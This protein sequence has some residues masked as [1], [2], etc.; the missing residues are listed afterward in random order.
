MAKIVIQ[1]LIYKFG[2]GENN[3]SE[4]AAL[5]LVAE[6]G[7]QVFRCVHYLFIWSLS[8]PAPCLTGGAKKKGKRKRT[9]KASEVT[10]TLM[11]TPV[12]KLSNSVYLTKNFIGF[13]FQ[14]HVVPSH[15][16]LDQQTYIWS[17]G[18]VKYTQK[19]HF[20]VNDFCTPLMVLK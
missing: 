14:I 16:T 9:G 6:A 15:W 17:Y 1:E 3:K 7:V 11:W 10:H 2:F 18:M 4:A 20:F 12:I 13:N 5:Y 8:H 19:R